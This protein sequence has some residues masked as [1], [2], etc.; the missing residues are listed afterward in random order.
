VAAYFWWSNAFGL[1]A[2]FAE[3]DMMNLG[4]YF[5]MRPFELLGSQFLL[6]KSY[7]RPFGAAFYLPLYSWFGLQPRPFHV[8]LLAVLLLNVWL[9]YRLARVL[10]ASEIAAALTALVGCFHPL[11]G[12]LVINTTFIYD[13]MCFSFYLGALIYYFRIRSADRYPNAIQ[14]A[15]FLLL[16]LCALNSKEMAPTLP[17]MVLAYEWLYH[18]PLQFRRLHALMLTLPVTGLYVY[19]KTLAEGA[20]TTNGAYHPVFTWQAVLQFQG[21]ALADL[22]FSGPP[23]KAGAILLIWVLVTL[24]AWTRKNLLLRFCWF[25]MVIT[26][27]PIEFIDRYGPSLYVVLAGWA[28]FAAAL[29]AELCTSIS[30]LIVYR[31]LRKAVLAGLVLFG[32]YEYARQAQKIRRDF[33]RYSVKAMAPVTRSVIAQ[34]DALHPSFQPGE[35]VVFLNDPFEAWDMLFITQLWS[36]RRDLDIRLNHQIPVPPEDLAR[37]GAIFRFD[38]GKLVQVK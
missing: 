13:A 21:R 2:P 25:W 15:I 10:G 7:Y 17:L 32:A 26:P 12:H 6:W 4:N 27:L 23:F 28:I 24:L 3:D 31:P 16:Y 33:E 30:G 36:G 29:F 22:L 8:V 5:I 1:R 18:R 20:M 14:T 11:M 37:A 35:L 19:G 34:L 38:D 9:L